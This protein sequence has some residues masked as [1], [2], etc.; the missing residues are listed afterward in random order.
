MI[1]IQDYLLTKLSIN[2]LGI[3]NIK[4]DEIRKFYFNCTNLE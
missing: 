1:T 2:E 4:D 3:E